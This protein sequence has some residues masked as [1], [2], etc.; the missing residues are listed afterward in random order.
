MKAVF[1]KAKVIIDGEDAY[2]CVSIPYRDARKFVGEM[3][4]KKYSLE[5]KEYKGR[6][7]L[8]ANAYFWVL[9]DKLAEKLNMITGKQ[10]ELHNRID[11]SCLGGVRLDYD[12]QRLDDTVSHRLD[13]IRNVL[14]KTVL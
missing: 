7:S 5:I 14:N 4:S 12:G 11:P 8:D 2:L 10:I 9:V 6:R 3:K 13:A 1:D